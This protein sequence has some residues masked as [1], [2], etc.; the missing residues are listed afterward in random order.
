VST[1]NVSAAISAD[2]TEAGAANSATEVSKLYDTQ[3]AIRSVGHSTSP[4]FLPMSIFG[5]TVARLSYC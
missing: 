2:V 4:N 5:Q 3:V 1:A